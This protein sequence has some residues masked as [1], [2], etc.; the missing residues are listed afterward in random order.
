MKKGK[1]IYDTILV[2]ERNEILNGKLELSI[3]ELLDLIN[4]AYDQGYDQGY[5]EGVNDDYSEA[6]NEGYEEGV[7]SVKKLREE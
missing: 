3:E 2:M 5:G 7:A 6:F 1:N 4:Y